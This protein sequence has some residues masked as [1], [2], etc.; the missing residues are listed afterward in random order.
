MFCSPAEFEGFGQVNIEAMACGCPV[1]TSSAGGGQEAVVA[2]RTGLLM[3][4]NDV[5]A[6]AAALDRILG[7]PQLR[8]SM[9]EAGIRHVVE[10]FTMEKYVGRV[11]KVYE[12]AIDLCRRLPDEVKHE[13]DWQTPS[14]PRRRLR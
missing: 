13:P 12:K 6:T 2:G 4:P 1:V 11:V 5:A 14:D 3:P 10:H 9:S 8:R 7:D